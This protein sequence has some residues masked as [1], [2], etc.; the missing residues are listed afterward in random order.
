MD[1]PPVI[2]EAVL[3]PSTSQYNLL[4][5]EV[6]KNCTA[7]SSAAVI[8]AEVCKNCIIH[9]STAAQLLLLFHI[10]CWQEHYTYNKHACARG[11]CNSDI[12]IMLSFTSQYNLRTEEKLTQKQ[13]S[14]CYCCCCCFI[15]FGSHRKDNNIIHATGKEVDVPPV[16]YQHHCPPLSLNT[17]SARTT[18][19]IHTLVNSQVIF[20]VQKM[21]YTH[22]K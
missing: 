7:N 16:I 20:F 11:G 13:R 21:L 4:P 10:F 18:R 17:T 2:Y 5:V 6:Y 9:L 12:Q 22:E 1:V 19:S 14:C 3:F 8:P 15:L